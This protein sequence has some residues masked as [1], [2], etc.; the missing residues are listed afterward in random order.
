MIS[1]D[2]ISPHD[3]GNPGCASRSNEELPNEGAGKVDLALQC[4]SKEQQRERVGK[5]SSNCRVYQT[6]NGR[7]RVGRGG[8]VRP[9]AE[10]GGGQEAPKALNWTSEQGAAHAKHFLQPT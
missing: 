1:F 2:G 9:L 7:I 10:D 8:G 6:G 4:P 3:A 5:E